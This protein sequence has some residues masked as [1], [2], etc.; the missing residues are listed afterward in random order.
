MNA[1]RLIL[2]RHGQ[3]HC[4]VNG[5]IGGPVGCTGL[6]DLGRQQTWKLAER[7]S[8]EH[9]DMPITAAYT[10]PLRRARE[11]ADIIAARLPISIAVDDD[12]REPDYGSGDGQPWS[13]VVDA[14][15]R[16][17]ALHPDEPIA[18][19]AETWTAYLSR[20]R[21]ALRSIV[22]RHPEGTILII[23]HGETITAAAHLFLNLDSRTRASSGFAAH[24]ASITR[25]EQQPL[26]WTQPDAGWRWDLLS[27][28]DTAHLP[29]Q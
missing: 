13:Q 9:N 11:T 12:L 24:Y 1:T 3:A 4:N 23:G 25:W 16:I 14:F 19:G 18:P 8:T 22:D 6:T 10:T 20:A 15:K 2:V 29:S 5:I 26:A 7:L 27:H 17:P 28:N 21:M